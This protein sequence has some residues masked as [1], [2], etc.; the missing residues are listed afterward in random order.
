MNRTKS[1]ALFDHGQKNGGAFKKNKHEYGRWAKVRETMIKK[2]R[3]SP[4]AACKVKRV[5]L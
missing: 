3:L 4:S 5:K 1:V 2:I